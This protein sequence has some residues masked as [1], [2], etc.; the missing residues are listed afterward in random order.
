MLL[1]SRGKSLTIQTL[2]SCAHTSANQ[3]AADARV[4]KRTAT[5]VYHTAAKR[6]W[7]F[8]YLI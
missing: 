5:V 2:F 1:D 3:A 4:S 6:L 8:S 7:K